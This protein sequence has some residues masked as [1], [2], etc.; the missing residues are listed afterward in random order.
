MPVS[1]IIKKVQDQLKREVGFMRK[2]EKIHSGCRAQEEL[3]MLEK[4]LTDLRRRFEAFMKSY[5]KTE[6]WISRQR[7]V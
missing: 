7:F 6:F 3:Q 1:L 2:K 4:S 5:R